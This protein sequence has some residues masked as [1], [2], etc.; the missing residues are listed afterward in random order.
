MKVRRRGRG[1]LVQ[2]IN[3]REEHSGRGNQLEVTWHSQEP[4]RRPRRWGGLNDGETGRRHEVRNVTW[5]AWGA[6]ARSRSE[7]PWEAR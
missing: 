4:A 2:I 5:E 1:N 7:Q 6:R 3:T